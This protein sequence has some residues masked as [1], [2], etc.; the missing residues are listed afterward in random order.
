MIINVLLLVVFSVLTVHHWQE[1]SL[2]LWLYLCRYLARNDAAVIIG[3]NEACAGVCLDP[4]ALLFPGVHG[5]R[6]L[7]NSAAVR[8]NC[9]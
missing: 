1:E 7:D 2:P 9:V 4:G 6:A 3:R 8:R 5:R